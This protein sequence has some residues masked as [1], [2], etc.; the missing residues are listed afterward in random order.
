[1]SMTVPTENLLLIAARAPTPGDTKTRLGEAIGMERAATLYAAFLR[2]LAD[3]LTP[4]EGTACYQLGWAYSP[5]GCD[6]PGILGRIAGAAAVERACFVPQ[7]GQDWGDRQINLLRWGHDQG[8]RRTVLIA[9]DS[10]QLPVATVEAAFTALGEADI[11]LG[12]VQ[13]G[14]Y[15]LIGVRGAHNVLSGV[16]MS[17]KDAAAAVRQRASGL[18]LVTAE[19]PLTFDVDVVDDLAALRYLLAA[20]PAVAPATWRALQ[21]LEMGWPT[22]DSDSHS[23]SVETAV[24]WG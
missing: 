16:P 5:P 24:A 7:T 23:D 8:Y 9:S 3:R 17:T 4:R 15:Y 20:D 13:D 19:L 14:G 22:P 12:P 21:A 11:A 2:D 10:P 18:G 6:F 1:M